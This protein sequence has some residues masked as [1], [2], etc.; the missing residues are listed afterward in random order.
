M[1]YGWQKYVDMNPIPW[2]QS[3]V[4]MNVIHPINHQGAINILVL[5]DWGIIEISGLTPIL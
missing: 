4:E 1:V 5:A 3:W 2:S